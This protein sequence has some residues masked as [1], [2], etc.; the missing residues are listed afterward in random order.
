MHARTLVIMAIGLMAPSIAHADWTVARML[1]HCARLN[2]C[3]KWLSMAAAT[4]S[5]I[6]RPNDPQPDRA[7]LPNP[8]PD[9]VTFDFLMDYFHQHP[10]R[11]YEPFHTVVKEATAERWPCPPES[12]P[13]PRPPGPKAFEVLG[14]RGGVCGAVRPDGS[15]DPRP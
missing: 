13:P 1:Q 7:C 14:C 8:T 11:N 4:Q 15:I 10:E 9:K 5:N 12:L 6:M 3:E 2:E